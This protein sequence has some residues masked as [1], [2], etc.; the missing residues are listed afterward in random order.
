MS[1]VIATAKGRLHQIE[2]LDDGTV[3]ADGSNNHGQLGDGSTIDPPLKVKVLNLSNVN[4][5]A[6]G[7]HH[8]IALLHDGT[9]WAWGWGY[10]GQLGNNS[11]MYQCVPLQV[12]GLS[13][14]VAIAAGYTYNLAL[15]RDGTVWAWGN[16]ESLWTFYTPVQILK[17]FDDIIAIEANG[18]ESR[19][20]TAY[21][22]VYV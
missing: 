18:D 11:K 6:A 20:Y 2:L 19:V 1:H 3:W 10:W 13:D 22:L 12:Q 7:S 8:S 15:K 16:K 14:I 4:A 9:V 17:D 21:G 5:I